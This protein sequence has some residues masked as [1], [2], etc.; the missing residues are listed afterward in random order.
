M[1][2]LA[3]S[4]FVCGN[5]GKCPFTLYWLNGRWFLQIVDRDSGNLYIQYIL[6]SLILIFFL[7]CGMGGVMCFLHYMLFPTF[8]EKKNSG[9]NK[10]IIIF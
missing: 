7:K 3:I 1:L 4:F 2:F 9:N 6:Y 10:I 8:L 5:I